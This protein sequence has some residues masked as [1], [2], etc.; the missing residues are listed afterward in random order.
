MLPKAV[1]A[2]NLGFTTDCITRGYKLYIEETGKILVSNQVKFDENLF[3]YRN[4]NM[5]LQHLH[6]ITVVDVMSFDTG[7]YNWVHFTQ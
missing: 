2:V 6:D 3:S 5:V 4:R 7:E 1:E